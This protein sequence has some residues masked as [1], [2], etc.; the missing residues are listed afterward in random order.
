MGA[1]WYLPEIGRFLSCDPL[2]AA[3][4]S[5]SPYVYANNNPMSFKDP[6]GMAPEKEEGETK[7]SSGK[8]SGNKTLTVTP[9]IGLS[10]ELLADLSARHNSSYEGGYVQSDY[11]RTFEEWFCGNSFDETLLWE[12]RL[13]AGLGIFSGEPIKVR[14]GSSTSGS[15]GTL[16]FIVE[17]EFTGDVDA[18]MKRAKEYNASK[19][20]TQANNAL[21]ERFDASGARKFVDD[22]KGTL[23]SLVPDDCGL[24][25]SGQFVKLEEDGKYYCGNGAEYGDKDGYQIMFIAPSVIVKDNAN[26]FGVLAHEI[27]HGYARFKG[28]DNFANNANKV[29]SER[30]S[31][32]IQYNVLLNL[33]TKE[34]AE[35][36]KNKTTERGD[37]GPFKQ[38]FLYND[39]FKYMMRLTNAKTRK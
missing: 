7:K 9:Y 17:G 2:W 11:S 35:K 27:N 30:A 29:D 28:L 6:S 32:Y 3:F 19:L 22:I 15:N 23:T 38:E 8:K 20:Q 34:H 33:G 31:Y 1:R 26:F 13:D 5:M 14:T 10:E 4:P 39:F 12:A 16:R 37:Y 18:A 24:S 25:E 21:N 36:F